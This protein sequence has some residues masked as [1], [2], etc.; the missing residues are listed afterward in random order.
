M[1]CAL[2]ERIRRPTFWALDVTVNDPTVF[3]KD[4]DH[5]VRPKEEH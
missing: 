5:I 4:L 3:N 2:T 1:R